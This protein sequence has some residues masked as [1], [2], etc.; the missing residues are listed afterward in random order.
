MT[1][2]ILHPEAYT[3]LNEILECI[4]KGNLDAADR[5]RE[6]IYTSW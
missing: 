1:R 3:Y 6:E 5:I 2:F 4:A